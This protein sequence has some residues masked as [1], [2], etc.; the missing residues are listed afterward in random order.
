V[1]A[2]PDRAHPGRR[3]HRVS[4]PFIAG[5]WS[6]PPKGFSSQSPSTFQSPSLRGSGRFKSARARKRR[7]GATFQ[8]PSLRGSGRFYSKCRA[9]CPNLNEFQSPSLRGSG[10][11]RR[12][13]RRGRLARRV[14]IPFIAGQWSL[15]RRVR[16]A[17]RLLRVSI[18]FIAGQWSLRGGVPAARCGPLVSIPFIAGQWSL[19]PP[20]A[21]GGRGGRPFQSPSLRGSGLFRV[22]RRR[23]R[24]RDDERVSIPFIAGQ[25]SLQE[26]AQREAAARAEVSIPFIAGQWSLQ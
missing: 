25:W 19:R 7:R 3:P 26:R 2:S 23:Q 5:Q 8:S 21:E 4:I 12:D 10:R 1:V 16:L 17:E 9:H 20:S 22:P 6:L 18:P 11:F 15:R 14:S 24:P 13:P